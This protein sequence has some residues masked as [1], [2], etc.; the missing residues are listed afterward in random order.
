MRGAGFR[1]WIGGPAGEV[2]DRSNA[3]A[4]F[5]EL[6]TLICQVGHDRHSCPF[7]AG[8]ASEKACAGDNS[9]KVKEG[10]SQL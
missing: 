2:A 4:L 3:V 6:P 1:S 10:A 7:P 9:V 8:K 5:T